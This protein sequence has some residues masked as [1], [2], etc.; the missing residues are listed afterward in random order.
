VNMNEAIDSGD[1]TLYFL[2][3]NDNKWGQYS[4]EDVN[5]DATID[6]R[7]GAFILENSKKGLNSPVLFFFKKN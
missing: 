7:D 4:F 3:V 1:N 5:M 2:G 6:A